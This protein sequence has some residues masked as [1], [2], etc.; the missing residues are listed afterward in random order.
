M[1]PGSSLHHPGVLEGLGLS[2][3]Q[4]RVYTALLELGRGSVAEMMRASALSR[5][6]VRRALDTLES[7]GLVSRSADRRPL[8][9]PL[10]PRVAVELLIARRQEDVD[11]ARVAA[12]QFVERFRN[13]VA[14]EGVEFVQLVRGPEAIRHRFGQLQR[15][16]ENEILGFDKPP[17]VTPPGDNAPEEPLLSQGIRYRVVY[18]SKALEFPGHIELIEQLAK[19]GEESRITDDVP[20]KLAIA[21]RTLALV[22]LSIEEAGT[23]EALIVGPC[24]LL[25][26][27]RSLFEAFWARARPIGFA[28]SIPSASG[29]ITTDDRRLLL[30][31]NGGLKEG[32]IASQLGVSVRTVERRIT[33]LMET[34][35]VQTRFQLGVEVSRRGW[36]GLDTRSGE[37]SER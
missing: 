21:D 10:S 37:G 29:A 9:L 34:L 35:V 24:A 15:A 8:F 20:M 30:L 18:D 12:A 36:L 33:R 22:P 19:L 1:N 3:T 11:R 4:E 5:P 7:L 26:A 17:Y 23:E 14:S 28:G 27:L 13:V 6:E 32:S 31:L 16:A 25:D 2:P